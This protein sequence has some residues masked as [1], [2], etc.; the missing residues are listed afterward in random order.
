M[1]SGQNK[2]KKNQ[3][4]DSGSGFSR[5]QKIFENECVRK[6]QINVH[7]KAL[8]HFVNAISVQLPFINNV[9]YQLIQLRWKI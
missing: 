1:F 4:Q 2:A 9:V 7:V 5:F 6:H 8:L 3:N